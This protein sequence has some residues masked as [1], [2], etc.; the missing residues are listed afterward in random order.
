[1]LVKYSAEISTVDS[2]TL[3]AASGIGKDRR[4]STR[5]LVFGR[6]WR[7][8]NARVSPARPPP[9]TTASYRAARVLVTG[10][11]VDADW[12]GMESSWN[13]GWSWNGVIGRHRERALAAASDTTR[14]RRE[15]RVL[16]RIRARSGVVAAVVTRP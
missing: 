10:T 14:G 9:S 1:M 4:S 5:M 6:A 3:C 12:D 15:L 2:P 11:G 8:C 7:N 13:F 16:G